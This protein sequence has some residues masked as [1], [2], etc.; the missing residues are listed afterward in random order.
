MKVKPKFIENQYGKILV[1]IPYNLQKSQYS[2]LLQE[3]FL[4]SSFCSGCCFLIMGLQYLIRVLHCLLHFGCY[5]QFEET[6]FIF[7]VVRL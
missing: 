7:G 1:R 4:D 6:F 5:L 3:V 2:I